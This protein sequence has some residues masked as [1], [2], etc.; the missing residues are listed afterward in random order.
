M[1]GAEPHNVVLLRLHSRK[2]SCVSKVSSTAIAAVCS[3]AYEQSKW[4]RP[5][6]DTSSSGCA[7]ALPHAHA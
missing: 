4:E 3:I 1:R 2:A 5:D 6:S 7:A